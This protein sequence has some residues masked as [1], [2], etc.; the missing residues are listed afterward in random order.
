LTATSTAIACP[1]FEV[2]RVGSRTFVSYGVRIVS[3]RGSVRSE[4][5]AAS[6][7]ARKSGS[8]ALRL[9]LEKISVNVDP[10]TIGSSCSIRRDARPD[11]AVSMNPP[12]SSFP[13]RPAIKPDARRRR[14]E[15]MRTGQRLR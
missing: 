1:S 9:L 11:S 3:T 8:F 12:L 7:A 5:S 6:A 4:T 13:P 10:P 14:M 2:W 15:R